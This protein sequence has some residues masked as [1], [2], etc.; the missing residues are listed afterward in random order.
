[1]SKTKCWKTSGGERK[2][3]TEEQ[4]WGQQQ[5]LHWGKCKH[6][7][8]GETS[9]KQIF[10]NGTQHH[11]IISIG[12]VKAL[13]EIQ[14]LFLIKTVGILGIAD[15]CLNWINGIC[16]KPTAN[17]IVNQECFPSK[18]GNKASMSALITSMWH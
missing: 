4:K 11:M 6:K 9:S 1:M 15:G 3:W 18:I 13:S 8:N 12:A 2:T 17:I 5:I 14:H 10:K 16:H 7:D